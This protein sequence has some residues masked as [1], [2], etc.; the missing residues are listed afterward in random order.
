[1]SSNSLPAFLKGLA[2][3]VGEKIVSR[4][5]EYNGATDTFHFRRISGDESDELSLALIGDDGKMDASKLRGNISRQ[6]ALSLC[7]ED[8]KPVA[9]AEQIGALDAALRSR[10]HEVF[11]QINGA[12]GKDQKAANDSGTSSP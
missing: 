9:T 2:S 11:E 12:P 8:G 1:M 4:E 6:V 3:A 7:D 5:I 10:F